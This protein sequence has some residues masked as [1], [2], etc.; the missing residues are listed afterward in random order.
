MRQ[1]VLVTHHNYHEGEINISCSFGAVVAYF[2]NLSSTL[3]ESDNSTNVFLNNSSFTSNVNIYHPN[4]TC[5]TTDFHSAKKFPMV[6]SAALTIIFC[7]STFVINVNIENT[8]FEQNYGQVAAGILIVYRNSP[9]T[10]F[11][12]LNKNYFC[13]NYFLDSRDSCVGTAIRAVFIQKV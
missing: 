2:Y 9:S 10:A 6:T 3:N 12:Y 5:Y 7:Q 4:D 1:L 11:V 8:K 13:R